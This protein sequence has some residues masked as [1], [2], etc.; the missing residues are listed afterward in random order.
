MVK[1]TLDI[2][3]KELDAM[4]DSILVWNLCRKH[5]SMVGATEEDRFRFTQTCKACKRIENGKRDKAVHLWSKLTTAYYDS[6]KKK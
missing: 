5:K 3:N 1:V 4:E 2:T 6:R